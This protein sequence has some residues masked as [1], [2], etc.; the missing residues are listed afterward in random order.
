MTFPYQFFE[1][2]PQTVWLTLGVLTVVVKGRG[3]RSEVPDGIHRYFRTF[4]LRCSFF[5]DNSTFRVAASGVN[6]LCM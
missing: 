2:F 4:V 5:V 1:F 3:A 6:G